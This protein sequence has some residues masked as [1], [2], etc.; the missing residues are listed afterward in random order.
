MRQEDGRSVYTLQP[1]VSTK[2]H[3]NDTAWNGLSATTGN[4]VSGP[5]CCVVY[6]SR[7]RFD[8]NDRRFFNLRISYGVKNWLRSRQHSLKQATQCE[9][10]KLNVSSGA[11]G[12]ISDSIFAF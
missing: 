8:V 11:M 10:A 6:I 2:G 4:P 5:V 3:R 9:Q 7:K 1:A 12:V